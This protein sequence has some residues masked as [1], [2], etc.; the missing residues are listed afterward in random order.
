MVS[1]AIIRYQ[2]FLLGQ[3]VCLCNLIPAAVDGSPSAASSTYIHV[4]GGVWSCD[5]NDPH[6]YIIQWLVITDSCT[7]FLCLT[8]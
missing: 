6:I 7:F 5:P 3:A 8:H 1:M 2:N 4:V